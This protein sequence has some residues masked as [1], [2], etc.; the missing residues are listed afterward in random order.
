[1]ADTPIT[2]A[3]KD[4][5]DG[6]TDHYIADR[7]LRTPALY[8]LSIESTL[9]SS[10]TALRGCRSQNRLPKKRSH[11]LHGRSELRFYTTYQLRDHFFLP[12]LQYAAAGAGTG[13]PKEGRTICTVTQNSGFIPLV[14]CGLT[15]FCRNYITQLQELEPASQKEVAPSARSFGT[16]VSYRLSIG[17]SFFSAGTAL[18]SCRSRNRRPESA[19]QQLNTAFRQE[20]M[21]PQQLQSA[22]RLLRRHCATA[23]AGTVI[24]KVSVSN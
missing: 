19:L 17:G 9:F 11:H 12:G 10:G 14:N 23:G 8:H 3:A 15:F 21:F 24:L 7:A 6:H 13:I 4:H 5:A 1:M 18:R 20:K 2:Q 22:K 16:P